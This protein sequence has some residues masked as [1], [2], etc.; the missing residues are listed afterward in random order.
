MLRSKNQQKYFQN[1]Y[2]LNYQQ[3]LLQ[4]KIKFINQNCFVERIKEEEEEKNQTFTTKYSTANINHQ[5]P[6]NSTHIIANISFHF[7]FF[8]SPT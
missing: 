4:I 8:F 6:H 3:Q 7:Q 5:P 2:S 1:F